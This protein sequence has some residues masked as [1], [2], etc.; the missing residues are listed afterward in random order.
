MSHTVTELQS[1]GEA[2]GLELVDELSAYRQKFDEV[3]VQKEAE[4]IA[5]LMPLMEGLLNAASKDRTSAYGWS[6]SGRFNN[7]RVHVRPVSKST[8]GG[9]AG[10]TETQA[11]AFFDPP[12]QIGLKITHESL[13]S[14]LAQ[15]LT[16]KRDI[17]TGNVE[18]DKLIHLE[19]RDVDAAL[20][21][22][23]DPQTQQ[24]L[25]NAYAK[26]PC[27]VITDIAIQVDH[28]GFIADADTLRKSLDSLTGIVLA[29]SDRANNLA[30]Q[31]GSL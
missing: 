3:M 18:L 4:K 30:Q 25:L 2:L 16:G 19:A 10:H 5:F 31:R 14:R 13:I 27:P 20:L 7:V 24:T 17:Q 6:L 28:Y 15:K 23:A 22:L 26:Y 21:L 9:G 8:S 29:L 12:F 11:Q 1:L